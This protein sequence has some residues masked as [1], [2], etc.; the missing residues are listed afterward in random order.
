MSDLTTK[1]LI[2]IRDEIRNTRS[3][4]NGRIDRNTE[5]LDRLEKRHVVTEVRLATEL[6]S[7][8]GAIHELRDTL[9]EDRRF[10]A[11][12]A[13]HERRLVRLERG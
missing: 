13:D 6:S 7:V 9:I 10:A 8:T 5:R 4:L 12:V 2:E 3:D 1:I 11:L